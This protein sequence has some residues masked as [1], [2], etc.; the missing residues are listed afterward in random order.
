VKN[1]RCVALF[2]VQNFTQHIASVF[3]GGKRFLFEENG[4]AQRRRER[5]GLYVLSSCMSLCLVWF[6]NDHYKRSLR[7]L[8]VFV[9][10]TI[11]DQN[12]QECDATGI[13]SS[14]ADGLIK[15]ISTLLYLTPTPAS[16]STYTYTYTS[17]SH[18][19]IKEN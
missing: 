3:A 6:I 10:V 13:N 17:T 1:H 11:S 4:F 19:F 16:N 7:P 8:G 5:R 12:V 18:Y 2:Y 9:T 15:I 14:N